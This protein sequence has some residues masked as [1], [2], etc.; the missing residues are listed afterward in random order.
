MYNLV[1]KGMVLKMCLGD[2]KNILKI[3]EIKKEKII[4]KKNS[5]ILN[6]SKKIH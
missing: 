2:K 3:E 1:S 6:K 4:F 5:Y